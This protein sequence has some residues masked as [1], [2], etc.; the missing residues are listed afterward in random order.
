MEEGTE[1]K[2]DD[3]KV[4]VQVAGLG[5]EVSLFMHDV[6]VS[7]VF[8]EPNSGDI[9]GPLKFKAWIAN[10]RLAIDDAITN[11]GGVVFRGFGIRSIDDFDAVISEFPMYDEGYRGGGFVRSRIKGNVLESTR[12]DPSI[13]I[14][15]HSEMAYLRD[16]PP[17]IAF[18]CRRAASVGGETTVCDMGQVTRNLPEEI[19][20]KMDRLGV[21]N[22]RNYA[23]W[24]ADPNAGQDLPDEMPWNRS[25]ATDSQEEAS[26][27]CRRMG[28][29]PVWNEDGS[30]TLI[31]HL[32]SFNFHP[33]TGE[34]IYRSNLHSGGRM[35]VK[36]S[37]VEV[38]DRIRS[39]QKMLTGSY[40]GD[41]SS[42]TPEE[43][44]VIATTVRDFTI[45]WAWQNGDIMVLDNLKM[46]HGRN[47]FEGERE[48][49]VAL[50]SA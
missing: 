34:K 5:S 49:H 42:L 29:K 32:S 6:N 9:S 4:Q 45:S 44:R 26:F 23:A 2:Y 11:F 13:R 12:I 50:L 47:S 16:Y 37:L 14:G 28:I 27:L 21:R 38:A 41:G 30:M 39:K 20:E 8:I 31:N 19:R 48:V 24:S 25:F 10:Q 36:D 15:L 22:V 17:R 46:A 18:F 40:W 35:T 7:P 33:F 43:I 1:R 3:P